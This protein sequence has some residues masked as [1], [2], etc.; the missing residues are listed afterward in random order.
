MKRLFTCLLMLT[1][2]TL[3]A[4]TNSVPSQPVDPWAMT[5]AD[6]VRKLVY[7]FLTGFSFTGFVSAFFSTY[8]GAKLLKNFTRLGTGK[9]GTI[10]SLITA[11]S[12]PVQNQPVTPATSNEKPQ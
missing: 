7:D 6:D 3:C 5:V 11:E 1:A 10:L 8:F 4:Q 2:L 9:I 12:K